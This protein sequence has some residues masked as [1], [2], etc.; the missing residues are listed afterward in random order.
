MNISFLTKRSILIFLIGIVGLQ[1]QAQV[2]INEIITSNS[3]TISDDDG[4]FSDWIE[5]Y[6]TGDQAI[7][8]NGYGLSDSFNNPFKWILPDV[9]IPAKG[10]ILIWASGK[11]KRNHTGPLHTNYSISAA[12]EEIL[13]THPDGS[14]LDEIPPISIPTDISYGRSPDGSDNL[15]FFEQPT[16]GLPNSEA[17]FSGFL[18]RPTIS[19]LPISGNTVSISIQNPNNTGV[20]LYSLDGSEPKIEHVENGNAFK[21]DYYFH[22]IDAVNRLEDFEQN[23]MVYEEA[24]TLFLDPK[25]ENRISEIITTYNREFGMFWKKPESNVPKAQI[26]RARVY[27]NGRYS[28]TVSK[29]FFAQETIEKHTLPVLSIIADNEDLFGF[30]DG[31]YVPGKRFFDEGGS[32]NNFV[33]SAN[34]RLAG[35]AFEKPVHAELFFENELVFSQGL[36][37]RIHGSGSRTRP[38]KG[39][40]LYA[41]NDYDEKDIVEFPFIPSALTRFGQPLTQFKRILFRQGGD[42]L[43]YLTDAVIHQFMEPMQI[44]LQ[45]AQPM[46]HYFNGEYWGLTNARDRIDR[47][48]VGFN[49]NVNPE[50]VIIIEAPWGIG[51]SN[52]VE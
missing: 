42:R 24:I 1:L 22:G 28:P 16:P 4:D 47:F 30:E 9:N 14:R 3:S 19:Q 2:M 11:D 39:F 10:F 6:N 7:N 40:R 25:T 21:V 17:G 13:L 31:I 5:L 35:R 49:Y 41:R 33:N 52:M 26:L 36:G 34:Y 20:L 15:V 51:N 48:Y 50:Q 46:V 29:T 27:D 8:L 23:T 38:V 45:R 18:L 37:M 43:D 32:I 44:G 12:G